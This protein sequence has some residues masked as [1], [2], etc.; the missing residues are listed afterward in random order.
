MSS[1]CPPTIPARPAARARP[2]QSAT[3]TSAI[4][5]VAGSARISNASACSPS[6]ARIAVASS[7]ARWVVGRPR[8]KIVVVHRRQIV[9]D[10]RI[11]VD[12]FDRRAR[13][14]R[15]VVRSPQRPRRL[16]G[17][18]RPQ[19]LAAAERRI[20][21]RLDEALGPRRLAGLRL[22]AQAGFRARAR[23]AAWD[24]ASLAAKALSSI[25]AAYVLTRRNRLG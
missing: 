25:G 3:R 4:A 19:P 7:K 23:F 9:V 24:S 18:E 2:R 15:T 12:A 1:I 8:L 14:P 6:P 17:Q 10:Q 21:H 16:H 22:E 11:G 5:S 13:A 20:A